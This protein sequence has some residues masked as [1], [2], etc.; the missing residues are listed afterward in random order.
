MGHCL[1]MHE[2]DE[3][4]AREIVHGAVDRGAG[5]DAGIVLEHDAMRAK[6][7]YERAYMDIAS[8]GD[9]AGEDAEVVDAHIAAYRHLLSAIEAGVAAYE[10][11]AAY[12]VEA[13]PAELERSEKRSISLHIANVLYTY[14]TRVIIRT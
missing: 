7:G 6:Q 14:F 11:V 13:Q 1:R 10:H 12:V 2:T 9:T 8:Y 4:V 5:G 3:K